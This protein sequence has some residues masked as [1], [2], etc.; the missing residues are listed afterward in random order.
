MTALAGKD[1]ELEAAKAQAEAAAGKEEELKELTAKMEEE[2]AVA[3]PFQS[4]R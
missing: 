4:P 1:E 2:L 3:N